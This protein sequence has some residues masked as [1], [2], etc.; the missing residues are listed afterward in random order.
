MCQVTWGIGDNS[1]PKGI[2]LECQLHSYFKMIWM[3]EHN[4]QT[5]YADE[6][7]PQFFN[8]RQ[9]TQASLT[10]LFPPFGP[11]VGGPWY[12]SGRYCPGPLGNPHRKSH[13]LHPCWDPHHHQVLHHDPEM[14]FLGNPLNGCEVLYNETND[15]LGDPIFM[16]L[17]E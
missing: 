7:K 16:I 12:R 9:K 14:P 8:K 1:M 11:S 5:A 3:T 6:C 15:K 17:V 13:H 4:I 10:S 2:Q